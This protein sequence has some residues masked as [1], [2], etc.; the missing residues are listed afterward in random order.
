MAKLIYKRSEKK[1]Q[2]GYF[3]N[4]DKCKKELSTGEVMRGDLLCITCLLKIK[5]NAATAGTIK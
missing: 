4:N 2:T 5:K 3:C 1:K